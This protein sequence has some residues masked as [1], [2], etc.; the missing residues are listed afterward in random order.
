MATPV[1]SDLLESTVPTP[2][3]S[4]PDF[5]D[6]LDTFYHVD[7]AD[8]PTRSRRCSYCS[9]C[10]MDFGEMGPD[11]LDDFEGG[12]ENEICF[13]ELPFGKIVGCNDPV[14]LYCGHIFGKS[15]LIDSLTKVNTQCPLCGLELDCTAQKDLNMYAIEQISPRDI[16]K[17]SYEELGLCFMKVYIVPGQIKRSWPNVWKAQVLRRK[18]EDRTTIDNSLVYQDIENCVFELLDRYAW[19]EPAFCAPVQIRMWTDEVMNNLRFRGQIPLHVAL[20][21]C[22]RDTL[23]YIFRV[24]ALLQKFVRVA[25][26]MKK[27]KAYSGIELVK[28]A[29]GDVFDP[30]VMISQVYGEGHCLFDKNVYRKSK[31][32]DAYDMIEYWKAEVSYLTSQL[33][34]I[35][36]VSSVRSLQDFDKDKAPILAEI[37]CFN[38]RMIQLAREN[39]I[40]LKISR[41]PEREDLEWDVYTFSTVSSIL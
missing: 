37:R 33:R 18:P 34:S 11:N 20:E 14:Q 19:Q 35:Q 6:A 12:V 23:R 25:G 9:Y 8:I 26:W 3:W 24:Q 10:C 41:D 28:T 22:I 40:D 1:W 2:Y 15:C 27:E 38:D 36:P 13:G 32:D 16:M 30:R 31:R 4:V 17:L 29:D 39:G 7:I 5:V 21:D